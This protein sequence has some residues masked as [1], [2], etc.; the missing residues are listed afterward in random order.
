MA[1]TVQDRRSSAILAP[2][3]TPA[4]IEVGERRPSRPQN[5]YQ[6][7]EAAE[8]ADFR[9]YFYLPS[10]VPREQQN[11]LTRRAIEE[12]ID[13]LE[14]NVP[15]V[16]MVIDG[17][18]IEEAGTGLWPKWTT[19]NSE[20]NKLIT[21]IF[22]WTNH[23]PR[24][25]DAAG[26][27][28]Y[29]TAQFNIRRM[30]YKSGDCFGQLL[31]PSPGVVNPQCAL[32]PGYRVENAGNSGPDWTDGTRAN[33]R[34]RIVEYM[35]IDD[36]PLSAGTPVAAD[37]LLHFHDP[38]FPGQRRG[39]SCLASA[40]RKM[41][42]R[43]DIL[44]ALAN[45]TLARE[46]RAFALQTKDAGSPMPKLFGDGEEEEVASGKGD[47]STFTVKR[48]YGRESPEDVIVPRL[49]AGAELKLLESN[50]P[51]ENVREFLDEIL[52]ELAWAAKR[53][54]EY[55]FF[56]AKMGQG[57]VARLVLQKEVAINEF[58]RETQLIRQF[59]HRWNVFWAWQ[60]ILAGDFDKVG[61]PADW[62][63]HELM[64]DA[65][66]SVDVGREGRL[67]DDREATGK[68]STDDYHALAGKA[69]ADVDEANFATRQRRYDML[70]AFNEKNGTSLTYRDFW[71][72]SINNQPTPADPPADPNA[73]P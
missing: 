52:R 41:Y 67:Y 71:P 42:R 28:D 55:I 64:G 37:D 15:A 22:H 60:R 27:D 47:G 32:I 53:N 73:T 33:A 4:R 63:R 25:F 50:R 7:Y 29:Y 13:F 40:A 2:D 5:L 59:C 48:M 23:D 39:V 45:G 44:K 3:G 34:G 36:A 31:R 70:K 6:V 8:R 26:E 68:M 62:W 61:V 65:D 49:P 69:T 24:L 38:F 57:T 14:K 43:E 12:R 1:H 72:L 66:K 16:G 10:L 30:I 35:V 51:S 17:L 21:E 20:F 56:L 11:S 18:A 58:R 54:P 46:Q 9:G 19:S